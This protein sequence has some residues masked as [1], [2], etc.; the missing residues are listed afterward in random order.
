MKERL[1]R[2]IAPWRERA[3]TQ[4]DQLQP[5]ERVI[6]AAGAVVV[7]LLIV[8]AAIWKPASLVRQH[9][10]QRLQDARDLAAQLEHASTQL[11]HTA[12]AHGPAGGSLLSVVDQA[13]KNGDLGKPLSRLSPDSDK[14]VRAW[15]EG[16]PFDALMHW[17]Y[18]LQTRYGVRVDT[19]DIERQ[20]TEGVV[21]ARLSLVRGS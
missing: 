16:V 20:P 6:V 5:R 4:F 13:S 15:V 1:E 2:L 17:M 7:A 21:N 11:P 3:Q 14:Q 9:A 12:M 8:Y 19:A 18:N 10:E